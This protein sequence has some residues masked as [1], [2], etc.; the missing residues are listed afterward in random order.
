MFQRVVQAGVVG[1]VALFLGHGVSEAD[2]SPSDP[3]EGRR[4]AGQLELDWGVFAERVS[5]RHIVAA[6]EPL[7]TIAAK[8]LG[9]RARARDLLTWNPTLGSDP[10]H[11]EVGAEV[12]MP[13]VRSLAPA[14]APAAVAP[15]RSESPVLADRTALADWYEAFW[16]ERSSSWEHAASARA[17]AGALPESQRHGGML[18]LIPHAAAVSV[19][20]RLPQGRVPVMGGPPNRTEAFPKPL[21]VATLVPDTL[22]HKDDPAVRVVLRARLTGVKDD[23]TL[24]ATTERVRYDAAGKVVTKPYPVRQPAFRFEEPPEPVAG[25]LPPPPA[26][27]RWPSQTGLWV[28]LGGAALVSLLWLLRRRPRATPA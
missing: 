3:P 26:N 27:P 16:L 4:V 13:S 10:D 5:R 14:G 23:G 17:A 15:T 2:I 18:A 8:H 6:G 28:A 22:V 21:Y 9:D 25:V 19:L 7:G 20:E 24:V 12:W 1:L 11:V